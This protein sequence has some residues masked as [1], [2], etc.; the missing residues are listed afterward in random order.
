MC[1]PRESGGRN[2]HR[3]QPL[4]NK[5]NLLFG[6][7]YIYVRQRTT[8]Q[9]AISNV[10]PEFLT[11]SAPTDR[12]LFALLESVPDNVDPLQD[13]TFS[14]KLV[15]GSIT[16]RPVVEELSLEV[17]TLRPGEDQRPQGRGV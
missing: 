15:L 1:P 17:E 9:L 12:S 13:E 2:S 11:V 4:I 6:Q 3:R 10:F 14:R 8:C 7:F 16:T 5:G